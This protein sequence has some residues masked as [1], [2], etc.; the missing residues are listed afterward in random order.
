MHAKVAL[1]IT[2]FLRLMCNLRKM[3]EHQC[4]SALDLLAELVTIVSSHQ[5]SLVEFGETRNYHVLH[6]CHV[7]IV[8]LSI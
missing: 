6:C 7:H 5:G 1:I 2:S 3:M 4:V 8:F